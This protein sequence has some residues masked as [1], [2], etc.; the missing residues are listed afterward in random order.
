MTK[1]FGVQELLARKRLVLRRTVLPATPFRKQVL[2]VGDV[3]LDPRAH[4]AYI[5][6]ERVDLSPKEF[7][8]LHV[9]MANA[10]AALTIE[11]HLNAVW[12][13]EFVGTQQVLCVHIGWLRELHSHFSASASFTAAY[14]STIP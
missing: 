12:G 5:R 2:T 7:D 6:N 8:L 3:T 4:L 9:L 10:G 11:Y 14:A 1:P 13:E